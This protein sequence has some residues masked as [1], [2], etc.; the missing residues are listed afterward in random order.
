MAQNL[1]ISRIEGEPRYVLERWQVLDVLPTGPCH[2][3]AHG[4]RYLIFA[5]CT[6]RDEILHL[7]KEIVSFDPT[8]RVG[9]TV[10]GWIYQLGMS[11]GFS[12]SMA[13]NA[14]RGFWFYSHKPLDLTDQIL[15][16]LGGLKVQADA[17]LEYLE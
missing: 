7:S 4:A 11:H 8:R 1:N 2:S 14:R 13:I 15:P 16:M 5:G 10:F 12:K 17:E 9:I 3:P 6:D